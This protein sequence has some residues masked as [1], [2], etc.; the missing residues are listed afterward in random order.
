ML[1]LQKSMGGMRRLNPRRIASLVEGSSGQCSVNPCRKLGSGS[2]PGVP[3]AAF[4]VG[5]G[6]SWIGLRGLIGGRCLG[7]L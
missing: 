1:R 5:P 3:V 4:R 6:A 2:T 7:P